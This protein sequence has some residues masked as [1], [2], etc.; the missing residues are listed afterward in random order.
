M[1]ANN[2]L[3]RNKTIL[4]K[5]SIVIISLCILLL[6]EVYGQSKNNVFIG[7]QPSITVE[8]FYESGE[9]DLNIL[10]LVFETPVDLR[11]N[12]RFLPSANYHFGGETS[13]FSDI[14]FFTV[15]PIYLKKTES[16]ENQTYG[17]YIG[18]VLGFGRNLINHHYTSTVAVEP[19]FMFQ[20]KKRFTINLGGQFGASYFAYDSQPNKWLS[21]FGAKVSLGFW[22]K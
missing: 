19:G 18:P 5:T 14:G 2:N 11:I 10:P 17:F 16:V 22:L 15:L 8:P 21:H 4:M 7:I 9:F 3:I 12:I 6:G 13:G 20:A 1:R